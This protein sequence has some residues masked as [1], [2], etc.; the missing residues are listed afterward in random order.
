MDGPNKYVESQAYLAV[1]SVACVLGLEPHGRLSV[2]VAMML[3]PDSYHPT[4]E[5]SLHGAQESVESQVMSH[6]YTMNAS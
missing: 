1:V 5:I 3:P 2:G 6:L 4:G